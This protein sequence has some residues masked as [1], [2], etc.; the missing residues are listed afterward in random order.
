[1]PVVILRGV[2]TIVLLVLLGF[3]IEE[4]LFVQ[5]YGEV[6][7]KPSQTYYSDLTAS[8]SEV[9]RSILTS[10]MTVLIVGFSGS[11]FLFYCSLTSGSSSGAY[12]DSAAAW[13]KSDFRGQCHC[14]V[15]PDAPNRST[16]YIS[17]A[18]PLCA[19]LDMH[20]LLLDPPQCQLG[21]ESTTFFGDPPAL[22]RTILSVYCE[23]LPDSK[24]SSLSKFQ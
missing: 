6:H 23:F 8:N 18:T 14:L 20:T 7:T 15:V 22:N 12:F 13:S 11:V 3:Y 4:T 10:G 24:S 21:K 1:M 17:H 5:T 9:R 19:L 16:G 2:V